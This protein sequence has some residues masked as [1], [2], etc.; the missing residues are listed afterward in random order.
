MECLRTPLVLVGLLLGAIGFGNAYTGSR[1]IAE[2]EQLLANRAHSEMEHDRAV[3]GAEVR[4]SLLD[5]FARAQVPSAAARSK[6]DFYRV[7][8]TGGRLLSLL[9]VFCVV[10]GMIRARHRALGSSPADVVR[11][12]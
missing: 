12:T 3:E 11:D 10:G 6:L 9:G 8:D 7:V 2:Y 5:S 4:L 1:K